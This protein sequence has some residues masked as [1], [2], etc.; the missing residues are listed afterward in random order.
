MEPAR[1]FVL[2]G[3]L[4]A[5]LAV[6]LGAFAAHGLKGRLAPDSLAAFSTGVTYHFYH[7]LALCL[8]AAWVRIVAKHLP[9][10]HALSMAGIAFG[11][12]ILLFS[13]SLYALA[14]GGPRW[15]G[16]VTPLGGLAF[17]AGWALFAYGA[18]VDAGWR[19]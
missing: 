2:L 7:A 18:F 15:L 5:L 11:L 9:W 3:T 17:L 8:V 16:P 14:L 1:L 19:S 4:N 13:G 6:G 12:G 10:N